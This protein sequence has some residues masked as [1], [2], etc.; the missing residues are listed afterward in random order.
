MLK[1]MLLIMLKL[2]KSLSLNLE[3][4]PLFRYVK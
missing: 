1:E 2:N 4:V 3:P